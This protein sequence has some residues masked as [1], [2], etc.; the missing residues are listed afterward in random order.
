MGCKKFARAW[1]LV[2]IALEGDTERVCWMP[3]HCSQ[4]NT[5]HKK[6]SNGT[7]LTKADVRGNDLVDSLA[8]K[9]ARRDRVP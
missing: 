6:L 7:S 4:E 9:I 2:A 5:D 3:A 8:E 1:G